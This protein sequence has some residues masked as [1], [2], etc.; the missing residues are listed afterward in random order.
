[1][2]VITMWWLVLC[3]LLMGAYG[4]DDVNIPGTELRLSHGMTFS[5][6][7]TIVNS[8]DFETFSFVVQKFKIPRNL[9][10]HEVPCVYAQK[11]GP[12]D[13][14]IY[15]DLVHDACLQVKEMFERHSEQRDSIVSLIGERLDV[16]EAMLPTKMNKGGRR[17]RA[18]FGIVS[19]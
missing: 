14:S 11:Q 12:S 4:E 5:R 7:D 13:S 18:L 19:I 3:F 17:E 6:T 1:M 15:R 10:V 2:G 8:A 9:F 16:V